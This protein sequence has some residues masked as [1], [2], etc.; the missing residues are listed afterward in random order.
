MTPRKET[1]RD[2]L[3]P[4]IVDRQSGQSMGGRPDGLGTAQEPQPHS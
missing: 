4:V 3:A 1:C 2:T